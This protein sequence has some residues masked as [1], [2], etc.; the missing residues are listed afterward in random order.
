MLKTTILKKKDIKD[1]KIDKG[2]VVCGDIHIFNT[3]PYNNNSKIISSRLSDIAS[4]LDEVGYA[5]RALN[6][7]AILNGDIIMSGIFDYPVEYVLTKF[8]TKYSDITIFINLGNHDFDGVHSVITPLIKYGNNNNH[9][10]ISEPSKF[11]FYEIDPKINFY[12][13]PFQRKMEALL[14]LKKLSKNLNGKETNILFIHNQFSGSVYSNKIK[15]KSGISQNLF[16]NGKFSKYNMIIASHIHKF[17]SICG[18]KGIYTSSLIP[19]NFGERKKE[20][21]FHIINIE[22]E[23]DYFIIPKAPKFVYLKFDQLN[24]YEKNHLV[25]KVKGNIVCIKKKNE[26]VINKKNIIKKLLLLGARFV[27]FKNITKNKR[28]ENNIDIKESENVEEIVSKYSK[29]LSDKYPKM[30]HKKI[31]RIG[32]EILHEAQQ[33]K[34]LLNS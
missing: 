23:H 16:M 5:A 15:S 24:E 29:I 14:S 27:T 31:E 30:R 3:Y 11:S 32:L 1:L 33:V 26:V 28:K 22:N 9:F 18:G 4:A 25:K 34:S 21:G 17:Q 13:A 8:L 6:L 2:F 7:P 10:V 20:H 19:L 12:F